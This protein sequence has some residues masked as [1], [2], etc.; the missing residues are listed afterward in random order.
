MQGRGARMDNFVHEVRAMSHAIWFG[1][2][3]TATDTMTSVLG[4]WILTEG[5][6]RMRRMHRAKRLAVACALVCG[7]VAWAEAGATVG[8]LPL[9]ALDGDEVTIEPHPALGALLIV[10]FSQESGDQTRAWGNHVAE[11]ADEHAGDGPPPPPMHLPIESSSTEAPL[12]VFSIVVLGDAS[13][14]M[15]GMFRRMMKGVM[16]EEIEGSFFLA[17]ER[18]NA[19][20]E[21]SEVDDEAAAY[22]LRIDPQGRI[23]GRHAGPPSDEALAGLLDAPCWSETP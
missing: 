11:W 20:R 6:V 23:C 2:G 13:R 14:F 17:Y 12:P 15:R 4:R 10:G 3:E 19:W 7:A 8:D 21:V 22:V 5:I 1:H 16:P 9:T 18:A